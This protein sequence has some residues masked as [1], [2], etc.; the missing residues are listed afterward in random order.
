MAGVLYYDDNPDHKIELKDLIAAMNNPKNW[1]NVTRSEMMYASAMMR[2]F[3]NARL[4]REQEWARDLDAADLMYVNGQPVTRLA[5]EAC[6]GMSAGQRDGWIHQTIAAA[7]G[8]AGQSVEFIPVSFER[9]NIKLGPTEYVVA[10]E[11][12][13]ISVV[14]EDPKKDHTGPRVGNEQFKELEKKLN[15][16][17]ERYA[18]KAV[19]TEGESLSPVSDSKAESVQAQR[20]R[21][22][23]SPSGDFL[24]EMEQ[25]IR[26]QHI[27]ENEK[28]GTFAA[29]VLRSTQALRSVLED[30]QKA[31]ALWDDPN[32]MKRDLAN[33]V[34]AH[35]DKRNGGGYIGNG[36]GEKLTQCVLN[37][38]AFAEMTQ[39]I[40]PET[41]AE[42]CNKKS[43]DRF[44]DRFLRDYLAGE[45]EQQKARARERRREKITV[46]QKNPEQKTQTPEKNPPATDGISA[47]NIAS[48]G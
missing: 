17:K 29:E 19:Q 26:Q 13:Q 2:H 48:R 30:P 39:K 8:D 34:V 45:R 18:E 23:G 40:T 42:A 36:L 41:L 31:Q 46:R 3:V 6:R 37:A 25:H 38:R 44:R 28:S 10:D 14:R 20:K 16:R 33:L 22:V 35:M 32:R 21:G 11:N 7:A 15:R 1:D 43:M 24:N 5:D 47:A 12:G 9:D 27:R 4:P